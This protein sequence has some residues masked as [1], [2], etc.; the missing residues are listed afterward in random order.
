MVKKMFGTRQFK[1]G[2]KLAM[3]RNRCPGAAARLWLADQAL[4]TKEIPQ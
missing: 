3:I 2:G 4:F 1:N